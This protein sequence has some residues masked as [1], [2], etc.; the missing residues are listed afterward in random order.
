MESKMLSIRSF[1]RNQVLL[2]LINKIITHLQLK[3]YGIAQADED[4]DLVK[5]Q[6][7]L[8][9]FLKKINDAVTTIGEGYQILK[10]VDVRERSFIRK[11]IDAKRKSRQYKSILF[12]KSP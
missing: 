1:E 9:A 8:V 10:G 7:I 6:K 4:D 12:K 2:N 3:Q 11:F 5:A